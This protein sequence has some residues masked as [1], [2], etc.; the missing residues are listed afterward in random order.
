MRVIQV[1]PQ[2]E[3]KGRSFRALCL[4]TIEA[5]PLWPGGDAVTDNVRPVWAMFAGAD[6][7]IRPFVSNLVLGR[8]AEFEKSNVHAYSSRKRGDRLEL[9]RSAGYQITYQ[10]EAEGV[11]ATV[12]LPDLF[13]LDP[14][15]VDVEGVRFIVL[16][17]NE[18]VGT[19]KVEATPLVQHALRF[20]PQI[21][22]K[23]LIELAPIAFLFAAYLDRRTRCPL[24]SDGRFYLQLLLACLEQ[25]LASWSN[26]RDRYHYGGEEFGKHSS[27]MFYEKDTADVG[28][29]PGIAFKSSHAQIEELL[30]SEVDRFFTAT[31]DDKLFTLMGDL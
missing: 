26:A 24:L 2:K 17:T 6:T 8:K 12:F 31:G 29:A 5:D 27:L 15:M 28:L 3:G 21:E 14:G 10:R 13:R 1:E 23:T 16:P 25:G 30:A 20:Y 18:W 9:L 7:E 22:E 19:Q 4:A 11:I